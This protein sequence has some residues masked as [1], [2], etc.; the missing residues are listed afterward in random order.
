MLGWGESSCL[1]LPQRKV[2]MK[3][4][5]ALGS[6]ALA[7]CTYGQEQCS[8]VTDGTF[9]HNSDAV[10]QWSSPGDSGI[11]HLNLFCVC[12]CVSCSVIPDSLQPHGLWPTRLLCP[13][14]SP[15]TNIGVGCHSLL[16]GIILTQRLNS[17]VPHCRQILYHLSHHRSPNLPAAAA[18]AKSLQSCPTLCDPIDGSP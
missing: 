2:K 11:D 12:V 7:L 5:S 3:M 13:W 14:D 15:G 10:S 6:P 1:T 16:Q 4:N 18:S 9:L 17:G 8:L